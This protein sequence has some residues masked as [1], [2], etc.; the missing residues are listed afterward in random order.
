MWRALRNLAIIAV[1][2][3]LF[4]VAFKVFLRGPDVENL[5]IQPYRVVPRD[6][7]PTKAT[8]LPRPTDTDVEKEKEKGK[9]ADK[10]DADSAA[11]PD[12][13]PAAPADPETKPKEN[14]EKPPE[15]SSPNS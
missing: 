5:R 1:C 13:P 14:D 4:A 15:Q 9:P 11:G 10:K 12:S 3:G 6:T 8:P 2:L 7:G